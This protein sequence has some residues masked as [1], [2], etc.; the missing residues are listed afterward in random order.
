MADFETDYAF[1]ES[2]EDRTQAHATVSD[3]PPGAFSISGINSAAYPTQFAAIA[4]IPQAQ[5]GPAVEQFYKDNFWNVWEGQ[6]SDIVAERVLDEAVNAGPGTAVRILQQAINSLG[7]TLKVDG[8]WGPE[9][10]AA[11]NV[12]D[13]TALENAFRVA[14]KAHYDAIVAANPADAK[15]QAAW[16]ARAEE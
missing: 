5:R 14:R 9:T 3:A 4:A 7:G 15:Y 10:V 13:Q 1:M 16:D 2:N 6:L 12:C 11:A 8:G